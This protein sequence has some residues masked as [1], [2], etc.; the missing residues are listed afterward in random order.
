MKTTI[1]IPPTPGIP[2]KL[3]GRHDLKLDTDHPAS[4]YGM[5]VLLDKDGDILDGA[6]F[7]H[8]RD[9]MGASIETTDP[10]RVVRALGLP[11]DPMPRGILLQ[12]AN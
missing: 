2:K 10:A 7:V 4:H 12:L 1:I 11:S 8:L 6:Q 3:T 9:A 5:G